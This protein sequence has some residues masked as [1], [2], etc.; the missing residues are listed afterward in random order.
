MSV[1][2]ADADYTTSTTQTDFT[3]SPRTQSDRELDAKAL[4]A[5][6]AHQDVPKLWLQPEIGRADADMG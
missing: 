2:P 3:W 4:A 5:V 1:I 6:L